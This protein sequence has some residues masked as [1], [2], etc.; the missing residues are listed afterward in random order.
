MTIIINKLN[1]RSL[2]GVND[3]AALKPLSSSGRCNL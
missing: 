3:L 2:R 1:T